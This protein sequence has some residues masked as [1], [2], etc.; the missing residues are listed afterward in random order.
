MY[1]LFRP[2]FFLLDAERAHYL[3]MGILK[4]L[5]SVS[6]IQKVLAQWFQPKPLPVKQFGLLFKNPIGL[7]AGFDKNAAYLRELET[8]GFGFVSTL[9]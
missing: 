8:L 5:C 2:L 6:I 4:T 7:G 9:R 3:A 1:R